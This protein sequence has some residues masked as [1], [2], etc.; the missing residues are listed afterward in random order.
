[1]LTDVSGAKQRNMRTAQRIDL[2]HNRRTTLLVEHI[3]G[4][5]ML[6]DKNSDTRDLLLTQTMAQRA[7]RPAAK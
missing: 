5:N 6:K 7:T 3:T 2:A 4:G 1:M